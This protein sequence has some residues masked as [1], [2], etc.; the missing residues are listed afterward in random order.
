MKTTEELLYQKI[1]VCRESCAGDSPKPRDR[2]LSLLDETMNFA[3]YVEADR[4][5]IEKL[6]QA[7]RLVKPTPFGMD[8]R[9]E[10]DHILAGLVN[11][12]WGEIRRV[13]TILQEH[14]PTPLT[15]P[16]SGEE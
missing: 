14:P 1:L 12:L 6:E 2:L 13:T 7:R 15:A 16:S 8:K 10:A 4:D 3:Y 5:I 11:R 9:I